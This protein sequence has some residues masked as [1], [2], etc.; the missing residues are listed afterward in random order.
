MR[1]NLLRKII[2]LIL[3][4]LFGVG[5]ASDNKD[6]KDI[7]LDSMQEEMA[8]SM[9][10]LNGQ[11]TPPYFM[12][13]TISD[14][15]SATV[16]A[17]FGALR[18]SGKGHA[19][20]LYVDVR[21]GSHKLDNTHRM[22][23]RGQGRGGYTTPLPVSIEDDPDALK[24]AIWLETD[25]VYKEAVE[26]LIKIKANK[27]VKVEEEDLSDDFSKEEP[28]TFLGEKAEISPDLEAWEQKVKRYSARFSAYPEIRG[29]EVML[30]A[31]ARNKYFVNSDGAVLRHGRTHWRLSITASTMA[32]DGMQLYKYKSFDA[33]V[34]ANLPDDAV[35]DATI[36]T[37]IKDLLA[38]RAAP[39]MEPYT[40][41]AIL[42]GEA[43]A[44]FFHEIFG[45][46]VE[47]HR[48]KDEKEGQTFT[49][50]INKPVLPGFISVY[51]DPTLRRYADI[52]L[53]GH[54]RYDDEGVGAQR[55]DLVQDGVLRNFLMSRSPIKGF[56]K[57][58]GHGRAQTGR[59]AVSRQGTL[60]VESS[61]TL[62]M[63]KLRK[64]LI[65]ECKKQGKPYGL[66]FEDIS[67]GFTFTQRYMP[68][69]FNVTPIMVYRVYVDGR[70]DQLVRGVDLIGTP[71]TSFSKIIACG[72]SPG[73]FNGYC[74]AESGR[75]LASAIS[76]SVLTTQIEVQKK[77]KSS[78]KPPVLPSPSRKQATQKDKTGDDVIIK[79]MTDELQRSMKN[80]RIEKMEKPYFTE[81]TVNDYEQLTIE[82][83]FGGLVK[84]GK[85]HQRL[86]R[87]GLRVGGYQMDNTEFIG[88][89]GMYAAIMGN[90]GRLVLDDDYNG[91][92]RGIWLSTDRAYKQALEQLAD[93]QAYIKNQ[94][95]TNKV[96]DFTPA[97]PVRHI[98]PLQPLKV[99]KK[100]WQ[101]IVKRV[102][103]IFKEY[104]AIHESYVQMQASVVHKYY[105]NSEGTV[106]RQPEPLVSFV[107]LAI[108]QAQDGMK[109][110]HHVPFYGLTT[111]DL[112]SEKEITAKVREMA[113][114]V[115]ALTKA[116]VL[117]SFIGPVV[118]RGQASAELFTQVML[119][120]VSG[121]QPPLSGMPQITQMVSA[122]KWVRRLN[123]KV[124]PR[125]LTIIDDPKRTKIGQSTLIGSYDI[126]DQG[127]PAQTVKLVEKG[128]LKS[129][130][131]ARRP[132]KQMTKSNGHGRAALMSNPGVQVSNLLI[133]SEKGKTY[134][135]LKKK[136]LEMC[137][138]QQVE[139][140]LIVKAFDNPAVTGLE[141][142]LSARLMQNPQSPPLTA[143]VLV[144]RVNLKDGREE[145]V[146]GLSITEMPLNDL[147][148]ISD[149]GSDSYLHHRLVAPAGG[150]MG[151]VFSIFS[152]GSG[153]GV[154]LP[155][156]ILAPS[157][158]FEEVEFEK[159]EEQQDKPPIMPHPYFSRK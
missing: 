138:E 115:T 89:R 121:Q 113:G 99:D 5:Y 132:G 112:P 144:Y 18:V 62:P 109:L 85:D 29:A 2:I 95:Q 33:S 139:Y 74:G 38:L 97:K 142:S 49:K 69:A 148:Y 20:G 130:L 156:S 14:A 66:Y 53:N 124:L 159:I 42:S 110:K 72:D 92:R 147:K 127:I 82:A 149:V 48:Q 79:A 137:K 23:G 56:S 17:S 116:P 28:Q 155:V 152:A 59:R 151:S 63:N 64:R 81:Y 77:R 102:S 119:P 101:G 129:L 1:L 120:H 32:E 133:T 54:Y 98:E 43:S 61:Q 27:K 68:Q 39:L 114:Q 9:S 52:D 84:S 108:T 35:V 86:L 50:Q 131:L 93:K 13:F 126:D 75:I 25:K 22:R 153:S 135:E 26:R 71:L 15:T 88:G 90:T 11:G 51:D 58:N 73:V 44:V 111:A 70:P 67:G 141:P 8:R 118:F 105:V 87:V 122:S 65:D 30:R 143:P 123:R 96:P 36:D 145:L 125:T 158:L 46:R 57:S 12:S 37:L 6:N 40:G 94:V 47:G 103:A 34:P 10:V 154:R 45:H 100:K 76:P 134:K 104:P 21:V 41:P 146:R 136:M 4:S 150:V 128:V 55:V 78:S 3:L 107:A 91:L 24:H 19:R 106:S 140:G 157:L 31:I 83:G 7:I 80:L 60:I 117:E 16:N